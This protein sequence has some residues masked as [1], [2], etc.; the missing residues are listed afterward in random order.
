LIITVFIFKGQKRSYPNE[1]ESGE[2]DLD[3]DALLAEDENDDDLAD[4]FQKASLSDEE[5]DDDESLVK[6]GFNLI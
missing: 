6:T 4:V 1:T 2:S 5:E 3:E